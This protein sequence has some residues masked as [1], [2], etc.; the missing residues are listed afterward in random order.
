MN[1]HN[2]FS[3]LV[4]NTNSCIKLPEEGKKLFEKGDYKKADSVF[5]VALKTCRNKDNFYNRAITRLYL[6]DTSGFCSDLDIA[7]NEYWDTEADKL[8]INFCCNRVDTYYY[9][10]KNQISTK[11]SFSYYEIVQ[12]K[13]YLNEVIGKYH[14]KSPSHHTPLLGYYNN[15]RL[16]DIQ[17]IY[18]DI[19]GMYKIKDT[20]KYFY[21]TK[22]RPN[23]D[24]SNKYSSTKE[25][26]VAFL[27]AKYGF[28]KSN[29]KL[30]EILINVEY[31]ILKTGYID[32]VKVISLFPEITLGD[33]KKEFEED[34]IRNIKYYPRFIPAK[35]KGVEVNYI[36]IDRISY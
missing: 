34:I 32:S 19:L 15:T 26:I 23:F 8:F 22:D 10:K 5:S 18:T 29:N 14:D 13:K 2:I 30:D 28:L 7:S 16:N 3:Q 4:T 6:Q 25:K 11:N 33:K 21:Y 9:N 17:Y 35:F 12:R 20:V 31:T 24:D 1:V 27:N 36:A